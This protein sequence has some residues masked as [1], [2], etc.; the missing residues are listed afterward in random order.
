MPIQTT[1]SSLDPT[2]RTYIY[3]DLHADA[4]V[5]RRP[6]MRPFMY[7]IL[8]GAPGYEEYKIETVR[9]MSG[10]LIY[11]VLDDHIEIN[12][13]HVLA[14]MRLSKVG[15]DLDNRI[16]DLEYELGLP[17]RVTIPT[18]ARRSRLWLY[19]L[20]WSKFSVENEGIAQ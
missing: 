4:M 3:L 9:R 1:I 18:R 12:T 2:E 10:L 20:G 8:T 16:K 15:T 11:R 7:N 14:S 13:L 19:S 6:H 5:E 17:A